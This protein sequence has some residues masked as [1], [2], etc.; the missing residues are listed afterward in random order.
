MRVLV[1]DNLGEAG[2]KMLVGEGLEVDVKT[3][4]TEELDLSDIEDF[5]DFDDSPEVMKEGTVTEDQTVDLDLDFE[6]VTA[7]EEEETAFDLDSMLETFDADE[8]KEV[9]LETFEERQ[10]QIEEE[11]GCQ[12]IR[13][14]DTQENKQ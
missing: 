13:I 2:I 10:Q 12:F 8:E 5:L 7:P 6:T 11:L 9:A 14:K 1:S 4:K 3:T